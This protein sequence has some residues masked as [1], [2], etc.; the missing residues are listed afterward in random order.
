LV[1]RGIVRKGGFLLMKPEE[2]ARQ[3]IDE[4]LVAA[5]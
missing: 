3:R 1:R 5:G 4:L 2:E